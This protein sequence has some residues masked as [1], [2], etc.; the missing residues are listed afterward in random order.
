MK[1]YIAGFV[2]K[3]GF[4]MSGR[5]FFVGITFFSTVEM[6]LNKN[7]K[8][9]SQILLGREHF[10]HPKEDNSRGD[11]I[12]DEK[13]LQHKGEVGAREVLSYCRQT[14]AV[15]PLSYHIF[16]YKK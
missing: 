10:A 1:N 2:G 7:L 15:G 12:L 11:S 5:F 13:A 8:N 14:G 3:R 4:T 6:S 9:Y 16:R